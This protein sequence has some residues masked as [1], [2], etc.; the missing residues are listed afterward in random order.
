MAICTILKLEAPFHTPEARLSHLIVVDLVGIGA[1]LRI[2]LW[3]VIG[4]S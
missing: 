3:P 4:P 1:H 2:D